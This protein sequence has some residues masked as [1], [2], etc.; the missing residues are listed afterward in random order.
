MIKNTSLQSKPLAWLCRWSWQEQEYRSLPQ[1][2]EAT[3]QVDQNR[4]DWMLSHWPRTVAEHCSVALYF[5]MWHSLL[6]EWQQHT[7]PLA[8]WHCKWECR[9]PISCIIDRALYFYTFHIIIRNIAIGPKINSDHFS[10]LNNSCWIICIM[11]CIVAAY[12]CNWGINE[13]HKNSETKKFST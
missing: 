5:W 11:Y 1:G 12:I 10:I 8:P 13:A 6:F 3:G 7:L 4:T 2:M 9:Y